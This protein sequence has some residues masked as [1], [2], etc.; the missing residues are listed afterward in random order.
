MVAHVPCV[1]HD[2]DVFALTASDVRPLTARQASDVVPA[3]WFAL[4]APAPADRAG[5]FFDLFDGKVRHD[6]SWS[7]L[8]DA[9]RAMAE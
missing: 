5:M 9:G 6:W 4:D 1:I 2:L 3:F 7:E 8:I